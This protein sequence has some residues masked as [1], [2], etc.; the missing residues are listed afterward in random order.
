MSVCK[1]LTIFRLFLY[2]NYDTLYLRLEKMVQKQQPLSNKALEPQNVMKINFLINSILMIFLSVILFSCNTEE[3]KGVTENNSSVTFR[4]RLITSEKLRTEDMVAF[5]TKLHEANQH[6][7]NINQQQY[8]NMLV[9]ASKE[10]LD[11]NKVTYDKAIGNS[12][13]FGKALT[14][15]SERMNELNTPEN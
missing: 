1:K 4:E 7:L 12:A 13:V 3:T 8:E 6:R 11:F 2:N 15:Y 10:Y 14:L 5:R 9:E